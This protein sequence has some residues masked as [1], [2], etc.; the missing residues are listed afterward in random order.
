MKNAA[1]AAIKK[2]QLRSRRQDLR[3]QAAIKKRQLRSRRQDLRMQV[4]RDRI[5]G[6][7]EI[8]GLRHKD[9]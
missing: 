3:M 2:R 9:L 4:M 1:S 5:P 8:P 6:H 7:R